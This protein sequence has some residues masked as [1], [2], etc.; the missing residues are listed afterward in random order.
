MVWSDSFRE[1]AEKCNVYL[2]DR[3]MLLALCREKS[4]TIPS[5]TV[6][7]MDGYHFPTAGREMS[8][9]RTPDNYLMIP[10]PQVS[11]HHAVAERRGLRLIVRDNGSTNGTFVDGS[12]IFGPTQ[13]N[14]GSVIA[15]GASHLEVVFQGPR[16]FG[17]I[18]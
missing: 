15:I 1:I 11:R 3:E 2:V 14:Y 16:A 17:H 7:A 18:S 6:L 13:V 4:L 12:R 8:L 10:D 5:L 9:G